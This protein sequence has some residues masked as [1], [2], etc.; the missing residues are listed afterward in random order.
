MNEESWKTGKFV[1]QKKLLFLWQKASLGIQDPKKT[2]K[3]EKS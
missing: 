1:T 2:S 3:K